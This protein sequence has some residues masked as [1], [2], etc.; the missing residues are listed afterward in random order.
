MHS[1]LSFPSYNL[2]TSAFSSYHS[3]FS[4]SSST[5]ASTST[6]TS[7]VVV[8][9]VVVSFLSGSG[10]TVVSTDYM[11]MLD[12]IWKSGKCHHFVCSCMSG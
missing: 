11:R 8:P 10:V 7:S 4:L 5:F 9:G 2:I 6:S 3:S 1:D 12:S